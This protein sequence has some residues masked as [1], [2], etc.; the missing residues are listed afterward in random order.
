MIHNTVFFKHYTG[1]NEDLFDYIYNRLNERLYE[2]RNI[3][4]KYGCEFNKTRNR[5]ACK[6]NNRNRII[7]F[8]HQM[9]TCDIIWNIAF[10][11]GWDITSASVDFFHVL[12][13]F[14]DE[15]YDEWVHQM[16][17][18]QKNDMKGMFIGYPE[19]FQM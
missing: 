5:R 2:A 8:L 9:R 11:Y 18:Q 1:I 14:V 13:H 16:T 7:N 6:I 3:Y 17:D 19:A 12:F 10:E 4:F 15:F